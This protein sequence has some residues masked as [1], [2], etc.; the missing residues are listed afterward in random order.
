MAKIYGNKISISFDVY[1]CPQRC[2][3]CWLG[4]PKHSKMDTDE[5]IATFENIKNEQ[6]RYYYFDAEVEYFDVGFREPHYGNDY[7]ELY[8]KVDKINR[9]SLEVERNFNLISLWR[10]VR[11]DEYVKWIKNR[12]IK[13]AQL[14]VF[15]LKETNEIF[16]GRKGAHEELIKGTKILLDNGIIPRWQI[17]FNKR[18]ITELN[19]IIDLTRK[20]D[21]WTRVRELGE[22]FN[23]HGFPY[24][25][26]GTGFDNHKYRIE[27]NDKTEIPSLIWEMSQKHFGKGY[28]LHAESELTKELI[29][30]GDYTAVPGNKWLWFNITSSWDV[31]PNFMGIAPWWK[32]GNLKSD[33][34]KTVLKN[35]K[36]NKNLGL[37]VMTE[38]PIKELAKRYGNKN[39]NKLYYGKGEFIEYLVEKYCRKNYCEKIKVV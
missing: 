1:G 32:L 29:D 5:V 15:G 14:K 4:Q 33:S 20:L 21:I 11:D 28:D 26:T 7:K 6:N 10:L 39:G 19:G 24:N 17:Y 9:C 2:K 38:V 25:S 31:Y 37:K 18:G 35:Y 34:W 27:K 22:E 16:Y 12:G 3:H 13:G 30:N 8:Q 23:I 36:E